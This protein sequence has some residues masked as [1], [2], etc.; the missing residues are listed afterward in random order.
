V[1]VRVG[2]IIEIY[3]EIENGA[4]KMAAVRCAKVGEEPRPLMQ[5]AG[6]LACIL[7]RV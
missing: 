1:G 2:S 3:R 7:G 4:R 6:L 5:G